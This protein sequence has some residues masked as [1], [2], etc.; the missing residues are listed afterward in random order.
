M[1][2]CVLMDIGGVRHE[3]LLL[4]S[5]FNRPGRHYQILRVRQVQVSMRH[6][7]EASTHRPGRHDGNIPRDE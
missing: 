1:L 2:P 3:I 6:S 7:H 4:P 5:W